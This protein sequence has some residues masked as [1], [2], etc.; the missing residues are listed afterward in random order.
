MTS[1]ENTNKLTKVE[2][3]KAKAIITVDLSGCHLILLPLA[4]EGTEN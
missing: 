3:P 2:H 1:L 4:I